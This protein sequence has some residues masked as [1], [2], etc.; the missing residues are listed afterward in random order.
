MLSHGGETQR[1]VFPSF[2]NLQGGTSKYPQP[3]LVWLKIGFFQLFQS[4]DGARRECVSH[5]RHFL[6]LK[7][8]GELTPAP[9]TIFPF[10][11]HFSS[12]FQRYVIEMCFQPSFL[13]RAHFIPHLR[14]HQQIT[15]KNILNA[16]EIFSASFSVF[17]STQASLF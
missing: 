5:S 17:F 16:L 3:L 12:P 4:E 11:I 10:M 1:R 8:I 7:S 9:P 13:D 15:P 14:E 2:S 6:R